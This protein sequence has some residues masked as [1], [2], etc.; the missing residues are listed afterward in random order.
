MRKHTYGGVLECLWCGFHNITANHTRAI[1]HVA[2][3]K[4]L[5]VN[6]SLY[7]SKIPDYLL[8]RY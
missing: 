4:L 3:V 7:V 6:V 2:K 1:S 5:I 8:A